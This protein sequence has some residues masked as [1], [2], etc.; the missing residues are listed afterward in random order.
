MKNENAELIN[1]L[2]SIKTDFEILKLDYDKIKNENLV[3]RAEA[4]SAYVLM[5][6]NK[7]LKKEL[8]ALKPASK[9][10]ISIMSKSLT[11]FGRLVLKLCRSNRC[12]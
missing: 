4:N 11:G 3:L 2:E 9:N 5:D 12:L 7:Q 8:E 1:Q 6:Q 10:D